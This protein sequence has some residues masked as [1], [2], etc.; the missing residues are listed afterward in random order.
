MPSVK[1]TNSRKI[2]VIMAIPGRNDA[3][4][5][6]GG[7]VVVEA[8]LARLQKQAALLEGITVSAA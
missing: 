2:P 7:S 4:V 8:N 6:A 3:V 1:I 5:P